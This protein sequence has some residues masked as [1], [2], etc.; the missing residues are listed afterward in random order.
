MACST[1]V[2][3]LAACTSSVRVDG[4]DG[5][6]DSPGGPSRTPSAGPT[7]HEYQPGLAAFPHLPSGVSEAPV[8]V[9]I[10]GGGWQTADPTG[11]ESLAAALASQGIVAMPVVIRAAA[12]GVVHPTP[13]EDVL[14]ALADGAATA[15]AAGIRP[16]RLVLL[17]HSSGA[18]LSSLATLDPTSVAPRCEDPVVTPDALVGLAGPYDIRDFSDAAA[19]LFADDADEATWDAANPVLLADRRP[20]VPVLLLHGDADELVPT[21]FSAHFADALRDGGHP[22]TLNVLP[23][24]DHGE[25]YSAGVAA[26]PVAQWLASLPSPG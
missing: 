1:A 10:P 20:E 2:L 13:V 4:G 17:G 7:S 5:E 12:D 11:L 16:T 3:A 25:V 18:H 23:A 24:V 22:T 19:R 9:M 14:C 26:A 6:P 8:V 15:T 21:D